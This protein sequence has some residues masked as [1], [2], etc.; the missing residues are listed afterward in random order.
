MSPTEVL[1]R[2]M[3]AF[4]ARD[5]DAMLELLADDVVVEMPYE[6]R[7]GYGVLDKAGFRALLDQL[8]VMYDRFDIEIDRLHE[9]ADGSGVVAEYRSDAVLAGSGV[10]Y[11]NRYCGVFLLADGRISQWREYDNPLVVDEAMAAH[12]AATAAR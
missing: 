12:A 1:R 8:L 6:A 3:Q 9:L 2:A 4:S 11:R 5:I 7:F 10:P